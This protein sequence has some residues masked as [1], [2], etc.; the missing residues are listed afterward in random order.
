MMMMMVM[1]PFAFPEQPLPEDK[2]KKERKNHYHTNRAED[3]RS[4]GQTGAADIFEQKLLVFVQLRQQRK[5]GVHCW[6][7][8]PSDAAESSSP[9]FSKVILRRCMR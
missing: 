7:S 5:R 1:M 3:D 6:I 4:L 9:S 8:F 2:N